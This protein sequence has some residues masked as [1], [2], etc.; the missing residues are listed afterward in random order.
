MTAGYEVTDDAV[1]GTL[2]HRSP[3]T[4]DKLS[5]L[6]CNSATDGKNGELPLPTILGQG[7][8]N[9]LTNSLVIADYFFQEKFFVGFWIGEHK[10]HQ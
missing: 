6:V 10:V 9:E 4:S 3:Q 8:D 7:G 5:G 1:V 2:H